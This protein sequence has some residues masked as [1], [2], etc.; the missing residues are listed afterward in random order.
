MPEAIELPGTDV[1]IPPLGVGT[2]SW[3]PSTLEGA[4]Q[5]MLASLDAGITLIDTAEVYG[6]GGSERAIGQILR[7]SGRSAIV[8]TKFAPVPWR[9]GTSSWKRALTASLDRL[10]LDRVDLYQVHW[11]FSVAAIEGLMDWLADE[12]AGGRVTAVGVSNYG[13]QQMR[14]A[15]AALAKRGIPLA[16]NQVNYSLLHRRRRRTACSMP[17]ASSA[18]R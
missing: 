18:P 17:A 16:S 3:S 1:A 14:R 15:H 4:R 12:V 13:E 10:G 2:N 9:V 5:A 7:E 11:P 6:F 8:A